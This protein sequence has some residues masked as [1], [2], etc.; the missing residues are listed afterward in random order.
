[1]EYAQLDPSALRVFPMR[2]EELFK[3]DVLIFGDVNPAFLSASVL[4]DIR[5]FVEKKGGGIIFVAGPRHTPLAYRGTPLETLF[6]IDL[7]AAGLPRAAVASEGFTVRPTDLGFASGHMQLGDAPA[8]TREIWRNLPPLYWMLEAPRVKPGAR[9]LARHPSK[10]GGDGRG[11]PIFCEQYVGAGKVLFHATDGTWRWRF[12]VG[13]V[14][15][16]RYWVQSI[17]SLARA[18]LLSGDRGAEL[19]V[20]RRQYRRGEPVRVRVR[21]LDE[22]AAPATDDGVTVVLE[23]PGQK[24]RRLTLQRNATSRGV[25]EGV[26]TGAAEGKYHVWMAEPTLEGRPP[27]A[28]FLVTAPPGEMERVEMNAAELARAAEQSRGH[29][30]TLTT[31]NDLLDDLPQG[32]PVPVETLPPEVLWNRWWVLAV[33]LGLLASEWVLRKRRGLL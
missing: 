21:F 14:F 27:A 33:F 19:T 18:K 15:F 30:Y 24:S 9:V 2:R 29:F 16:A 28:D 3:Y 23:Q 13:D 4:G 11:L 7:D 17:R 22:R 31:V 20:D 32:R 8:E 25:F 1:L 26:F 12:R 6:P 10:L 5:D